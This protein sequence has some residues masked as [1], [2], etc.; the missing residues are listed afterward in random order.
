MKTINH[1]VQKT[2]RGVSLIIALIASNAQSSFGATT[3]YYDDFESYPVQNP[4]PN[5]LTNGPA[6]GEWFFVDPIEPITPLEHRIF[7]STALGSALYSRVWATLTNNARLTNAIS[8]DALPPGNHTYRLSFVVAADTLTASRFI[9]FDYSISSSAGPLTLLSGHNLDNSQTFDALSGSGIATAGTKGKTDDRRFEFVFQNDAL[10]SSDKIF[11]SITRVTNNAGA[12]LTF[13]LDDVRL[14]IDD[15]NPPLVQSVEPVLTLQHVHVTFSEPVDPATATDIAN[16]S[17]SGGSLSVLGATL[18]SPSTVELYTTDQDPNSSH[19]L[20][21]SGVLGQTG[22]SITSTQLNF[23][24]P[25]LTISPVRYDAGTTTTL[26][27]GPFDPTTPEA[28]SWVPVTSTK[29]GMSA[30]PVLDDLSTGFNA[31]RVTDNN[32][33]S[34]GGSMNY[35]I[36]IDQA[37]IDLARTNGWRIITRN[38]VVDNF[39]SAA[40]DQVIIYADPVSNVRYGLFWGVDANLNLYVT[41]LGGVTA[42][43]TTGGVADT[44]AYHTNMMI[45]NPATKSVSYYF[46]G[47]L[48]IPNYTGQVITVPRGLTF[49]SASSAAQGEMNYNLVQLDVVDATRPVATVNPQSGAYGVGQKVTFSAAFSPFV[50]SYQWLSNGVAIAGATATNYTTSFISMENDGDQYQLRA[51]SGLGD[52][53]TAPAILTVTQDTNPPVIVSASGSLLHDRITLTF[54]EPVLETY[55]T[56]LA[57]YSWLNAGVTNLSVRQL[58]PL[59]VELRAGPFEIG[60]NYTVRVSNIR[61]TSN[62]IIAPD[63]PAQIS[64]SQMSIAAL[65]D[66]GDTTSKPSGAPDPASP[67]GGNWTP[68][69]SA[70]PDISTNAIFDDLGTGLNA[71]QI[72]D[73]TAATAQFASYTMQLATNLQDNARQF[74]WVLTLRSR[75][76]ENLGAG[77]AMFSL[78]ENYRLERYGLIFGA[79]TNNDLLVGTSTTAGFTTNILTTGGTALDAYHLHQVV[80]DPATARASYYFDGNL[81]AWRFPVSTPNNSL[82]ELMFGARASVAMGTMNFNLVEFSIANGPYVSLNIEGANAEISYRGVLESASALANPTMWTPVATNLDGGTYSVPVNSSTQLY[83]RARNP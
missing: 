64:F 48:I 18:L 11:F 68:E 60:S 65:Y 69:I 2:L 20:Q 31:W 56:D 47:R 80:Y 21:I 58:D 77:S 45:Y 1:A 82:A 67:E 12:A 57:N 22:I 75:L 35:T 9:D 3:L 17:F 33:T 76:A 61:D 37:S 39:G 49:G 5:P 29:A 25:A 13:F 59:T 54:S 38:R 16:Y 19:T 55:A 53:E 51:L 4:A 23:T 42:T 63:S 71:W 50:N 7:D 62:L 6:G 74:G 72:R 26:P 52:V 8:L 36:P 27:S 10:T 41:P 14:A 43:L 46:D 44:T 81:I 34:S 40:T 70:N 24:T 78:Y 73:G 79:D 28:G 30:G 83:F 66:A 32:G 15:T